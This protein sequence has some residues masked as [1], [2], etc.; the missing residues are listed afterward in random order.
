[1]NNWISVKKYLPPFHEQV[2]IYIPNIED[3]PTIN[4]GYMETDGNFYFNQIPD[5]IDAQISE[6]IT[7]WMSLPEPPNE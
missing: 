1:M 7:H 5:N 3:C 4:V 6:N 2:L